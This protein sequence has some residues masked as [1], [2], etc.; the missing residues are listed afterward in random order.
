MVSPGGGHGRGSGR[1]LRE[2]SMGSGF[3]EALMLRDNRR[4]QAWM[5]GGGGV[6]FCRAG[7]WVWDVGV[8]LPG[9]RFRGRWDGDGSRG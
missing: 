4:S 2:G 5:L 3:S 7:D 6:G 8:R 1:L 9:I